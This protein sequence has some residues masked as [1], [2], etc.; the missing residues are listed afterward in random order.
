MEIIV[1][2]KIKKIQF[3]KGEPDDFGM[4]SDFQ[5]YIIRAR[6]AK[7]GEAASAEAGIAKVYTMS[8]GSVPLNP[9]HVVGDSGV[10]DAIN[11]AVERL[12]SK[13]NGYKIKEFSEE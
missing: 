5:S 3:F 13:H 9:D 1:D 10:D 4:P 12:K 6:I 7:K 2:I 8:N 11:K